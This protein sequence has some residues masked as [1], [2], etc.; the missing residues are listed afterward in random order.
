MGW[1][2]DYSFDELKRQNAN[3]NKNNAYDEILHYIKI[4]PDCT[5]ADIR[6]FIIKQKHN[7]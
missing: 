1:S 2:N 7:L 4:N 5:V 3:R 6:N